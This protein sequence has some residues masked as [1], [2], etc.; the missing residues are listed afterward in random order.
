[1]N[2]V[3]IGARVHSGWA[4]V[5]AVSGDP[6]E[7]PCGV[8]VLD[9]RR[10]AIVDSAVVGANQPYHFAENLE[11]P[12]AE[13]YLANCAA[14]SERL[15]SAAIREMAQELQI[16]DYQVAG[17]AIVLA[18]G[19]PLPG[20]ADI[21]ASHALIHTAEGEF[22]RT[23]LRQACEGQGIPVTGIRQHDLEA[24]AKGLF[25]SAANRLE[26][27]IAGLG[28]SLGPPWTEDQKTAALAA[29]IVLADLCG[30][31]YSQR[32]SASVD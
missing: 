9:R 4:A 25:G 5:L 20:L 19:R 21:L 23:A 16:R 22:F 15:A 31:T 28:R 1:M 13:K 24:R 32:P 29:W 27:C 11:L 6:E 8:E 10:M 30:H 12:D 26:K 2:P 14:V 3:V 18:A 17:S 7:D